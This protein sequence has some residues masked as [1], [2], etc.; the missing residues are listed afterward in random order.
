[1]VG[2][3]GSPSPPCR[4]V[5]GCF[6]ASRSARG[7]VPWAKVAAP[8]AGEG[9]PSSGPRRWPGRSRRAAGLSC[10]G[11]YI[12]LAPD[13]PSSPAGAKNS[14]R[15]DEVRASRLIEEVSCTNLRD[16]ELSIRERPARRTSHG[17]RRPQA[18]PS[19]RTI[20]RARVRAHRRSRRRR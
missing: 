12:R 6:P 7:D 4:R 20:A 14:L 10:T 15:G 16:Q 1:M 13:A 5:G 11:A 3:D 17:D 8:P 19:G 9:S 18:L 2:L